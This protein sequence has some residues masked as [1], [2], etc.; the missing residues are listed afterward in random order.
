MKLED[1]VKACNEETRFVIVNRFGDAI[2][3]DSS[4][5]KSA[6]MKQEVCSIVVT[7]KNELTVK[8]M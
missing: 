7:G 3:V 5:K 4:L 2:K 1:L 8:I 6:I